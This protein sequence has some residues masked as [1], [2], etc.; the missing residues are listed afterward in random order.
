LHDEEIIDGYTSRLRTENGWI[1]KF[2]KNNGEVENSIYI[3][4]KNEMK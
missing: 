1:Y 2:M 3:P 4:D